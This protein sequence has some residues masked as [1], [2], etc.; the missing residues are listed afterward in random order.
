[1]SRIAILSIKNLLHNLQIVKNHTS[2][3]KIIAMVKADAYG[4]GIEP[5]SLA[6]EKHVN[7]FGVATIEE[8][9]KLRKIGITIPILLTEGVFTQNELRIAANKNLHVVFHSAEQVDLLKGLSFIVP[10][11]TWIKIDTGMGRLGFAA[12]EVNY[13]YNKLLNNNQLTKPIRILSHFACA[14]DFNHPLNQQQIEVF[15]NIIT[16]IKGEYSLCNSAAIF[17]FPQCH[18]NFVRPGLALYGASPI[19]G[20]MPNDFNLKPVMTIKSKLIAIHS[21]PKGSSIGYGARYSCVEDMLIGV[22]AFGY[23]DGYP[24]TAKDGCPVLINNEICPLV[25]RVSMDMIT[26]NLRLCRNAK[27]GD[28]VILWGEG[29]S[30]ENII[31]FTANSSYDIM[32]GIKNRVKKCLV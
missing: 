3:S 22:V 9:L 19:L 21:V 5:I 23:G 17:Q 26:V 32:T 8:A 4:H 14:D 6:L 13:F 29:L 30:I 2:L 25:G 1:M 31:K 15:Q 20:K 24:I 7:M 28:S 11:Q 12:K 16:D 27:I 18:Y 10:L